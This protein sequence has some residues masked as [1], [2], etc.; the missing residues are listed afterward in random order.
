[1]ASAESR[2]SRLL[3]DRTLAI[4]VAIDSATTELSQAFATHDQAIRDAGDSFADASTV[5][6]DQLRETIDAS[7]GVI[8]GLFDNHITALASRHAEATDAFNAQAAG[9]REAFVGHREPRS[10]V[11]S[12]GIVTTSTRSASD[13]RAKAL[14]VW[15]PSRAL[16]HR[17]PMPSAT[18]WRAYLA[19][20]SLAR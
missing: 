9:M 20:L 3:E 10:P 7:N 1:M 14:T 12:Q 18:P 13:C 8:R 2:M 6:A 4:H 11:I 15:L 16:F 19:D 17:R 5:R